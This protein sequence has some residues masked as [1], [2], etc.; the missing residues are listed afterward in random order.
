LRCLPM[1]FAPAL[2]SGLTATP[3][4]VTFA[5]T[6]PD[7]GSVSGTSSTVTW[8]ALGG[9]PVQTWTLSV[10]APASAFS[11][12]ATVPVSAVTVSCS[13]ASATGIGGT[14][15]CG[16]PFT[17][18]TSSHQVASGAE[19]TASGTYT[20][21]IA[22]SLADSWKYVAASACTLILTYTAVTP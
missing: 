20:V 22:F 11:G 9:L 4:T 13:S 2:I 19:G 21:K 3:G 6:D 17:L 18:S 14:A 8:T 7:L 10:Q 15:T 16:G 1:G 12:C 5:A